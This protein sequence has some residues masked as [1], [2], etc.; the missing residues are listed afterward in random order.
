MIPCICIDDKGRP[1]DFPLSKWLVEDGLYHIVAATVVLPQGILGF[2]LHEVKMDSSCYP[3]KF[4]S[5]HRFAID[6]QFKKQLFEMVMGIDENEGIDID[7]IIESQ[8]IG[9]V[10]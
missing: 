2:R 1:A 4:F 3:Y 9:F 8:K 7:G 10:S 6:E 5:S